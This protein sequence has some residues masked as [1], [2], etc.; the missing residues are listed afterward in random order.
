MQLSTALYQTQ[1][2]LQSSESKML[3][4]DAAA[5]LV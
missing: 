3:S 5:V 4:A 1:L 2:L